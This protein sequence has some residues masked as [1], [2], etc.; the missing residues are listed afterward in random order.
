MCALEEEILVRNAQQIIIIMD[1]SAALSADG[2][3]N[4]SG[5]SGAFSN[6]FILGRPVFFHTLLCSSSCNETRTM[7]ECGSL[8]NNNSPC[9][10]F[11]TQMMLR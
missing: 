4:R 11:A 2:W 8:R 1:V 9:F 6:K 5:G 3:R 7:R 10:G